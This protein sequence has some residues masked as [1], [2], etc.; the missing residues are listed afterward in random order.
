MLWASLGA[1]CIALLVILSATIGPGGAVT[2]F[3]ESIVRAVAA[4]RTPFLSSLMTDTSSLGSMALMI[5]FSVIAVAVLLSIRDGAAA[6]HLVIT[7][8]LSYAISIYTKDFY[9]RPRPTI[10]EQLVHAS[11]FSFPS[12]HSVSSAAL[13]VTLAILG[14]RHVSTHKARITLAA[15]AV[16][17]VAVVSFS[18]VYLGVHYPSDTIGGAAMGSAWAL[19]TAAAFSHRYWSRTPPAR[20]ATPEAPASK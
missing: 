19:A 3:D 9:E 18:R 2:A 7:V 12:G 6:L 16:A 4:H 11:G 5:V 13:Y 10:V 20:A 17:L 15:I 14:A 8:S 1:L